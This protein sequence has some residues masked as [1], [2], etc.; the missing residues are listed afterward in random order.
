MSE[1]ERERERA[2]D[3]KAS[4]SRLEREGACMRLEQRPL[5]DLSIDAIE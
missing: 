5:W 4:L 3:P 1:R 2:R